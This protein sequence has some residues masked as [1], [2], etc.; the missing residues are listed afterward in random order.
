MKKLL[1]LLFVFSAIKLSAQQVPQYTNYVFNYFAIN[2]AVAGSKEC[3]DA[4]FGYRTQ[5]VG[6]DGAP[7]TAFGSLHTVLKKNN[8]GLA[9]KHAMGILIESDSYGPF[10]R[11]KLKVAYAYHFPLNRDILMSM[12]V[13]LGVEQ[14]SFRSG[15]VTLINF[16]DNAIGRANNAIIFPEISPGIFL[17][18]KKWFGG[19]SIQ[20]TLTSE[21][22]AAGTAESELVRH[23]NIMGG[24]KFSGRTWSIVPSMLIKYAPN[25]PYAVDVNI[26]ADYDTKFAFG[27]SYRT[28]DAVAALV[29]FVATDNLTI[30]YSYDYTLS[31]IQAGA[32]NTHEV[33]IGI[34]P[35]GN[36]K[37]SKY[38]CPT[39]N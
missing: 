31:K 26:M 3:L 19:V 13:F 11:A 28:T 15:D 25:V 5:W 4:K 6:F 18:S 16:N 38:A 36:N 12:G 17:Q 8:Y 33:M 9:N 21:I 27:L 35:C 2:P 24:L 14:L 34:N 39:F 1:L 23:A 32:S 37:K 20:Q 29:K 10:R 7:K 22:K 30:G